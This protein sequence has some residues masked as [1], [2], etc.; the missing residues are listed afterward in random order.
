MPSILST[1]ELQS[2]RALVRDLALPDEALILRATATP[3]NFGGQTQ[4]WGTVDVGG[5]I[6][7][8]CRITKSAPTLRPLAGRLVEVSSWN[9]TFPAEWDIR[10]GDRISYTGGTVTLQVTGIGAPETWEMERRVT[11]TDSA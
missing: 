7:Q 8:P 3:D 2:F 9:V 4:T 11:C 1:A 6:F 5:T 10:I